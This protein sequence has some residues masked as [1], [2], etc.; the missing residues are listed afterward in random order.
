M[1][2][3]SRRRL[4]Q[5]GMVMTAAAIGMPDCFLNSARAEHLT[6][7]EGAVRRWTIGNE[8]ITRT[9]VFKPGVGLYTEALVDGLTGAKFISQEKVPGIAAEFSFACNGGTYR[10]VYSNFSLANAEESKLPNGKMLS[11]RL[12]QQDAGIEVTVVYRCY[13]GHSAIRKHL[14]LRNRGAAALKLTHVNIEALGL[15]LG[16]E[17]EIV[18]DAQYGAIPREIF[19][20]GRSED[21]G[22]LLGNSRTHVGVAILNEVPGYMK[23]TEISGWYDPD[24]VSVDVLYDTDLMPFERFLAPDE[25]FKTGS[26]SLATYRRDDGFNDP[27]W[28]LP[29]YTAKVLE[30]RVDE[31]GPPWIY[32]TW[33]PFERGINRDIALE[34]I[35]AAG[36]MGMDIFT[37]DD[38]WQ[39]EYGDNAVNLQPFP[40]GLKPILDALESRGMRLGLWIPMAAIG[41]T[42]AQFRNHPEQAALDIDGK[43]KITGTM[44]GAKA[45]MCMASAFRDNAAERINDA[46][47]RFHLAYVKLDLTTIFN[48][49]GEAPGC[50]AKGHYH[51]SWAE[52]LNM[53]YEGIGYV[54]SKV[55]AVHPDVLLDLT[56]ELWGQKHIIDAGLLAAG[57]LDW[58]SNVD[59]KR[60]DSAGPI[61]ARQLL[62]QRA[63]SMPVESMLIGNIHA[64]VPSIQESFTTAIGSAPLF[65]G[66]L[67]NLS[68]SDL[69]W[70]REK[71]GW[72]KALRRRTMI[73]E[74]FFPLGSWMQTSSDKWD[75]FARLAHSGDG[76][77]AL[78]RN[79]SQVATALVQI[80]VMAPG[81]FGLRSALTGKDIGMFA[82][83]DFRRGIPVEF[84][85][86][87]EIVEVAAVGGTRG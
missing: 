4:I 30:R 50:W 43:T 3:L 39:Q 69:Q 26:V 47:E 57:D 31:H 86:Q 84:P 82:A 36:V 59:D 44:A 51:H 56:F 33:E 12:L 19:Y 6:E 11:V 53:I 27:R 62:Y 49:Y 83:E 10:G 61:Q 28:V 42:T 17:N 15:S 46:I 9:V 65:L 66:D 78:F 58:I 7:D 85:G 75:G 18:L 20:T 24:H 29:S 22:L 54:T 32:N 77:I 80:S 37:I 45:V 55:Y 16:P 76:V 14:V 40:G 38:G 63:A 67:R 21:A 5:G 68:K 1:H 2:L 8:K 48:A 41:M 35:E 34:L 74:S 60:P 52:S 87:V 64:E 23:R 81:K 73:S 70:F 13:D 71:I 79:K 72:F 25:E